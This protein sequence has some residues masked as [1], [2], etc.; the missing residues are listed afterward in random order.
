MTFWVYMQELLWDTCL[1]EE[2][3]DSRIFASFYCIV[4]IADLLFQ[5]VNTNLQSHQ[6]GINIP[7][8][9]HPLQ[10]LWLSDYL[11]FSNL[12]SKKR[13]FITVLVFSPLIINGTKHLIMLIGHLGFRFSE[14][15]F[16]C[17]VHPPTDFIIHFFFTPVNF[18]FIVLKY[19]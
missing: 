11:L 3:L 15:L 13:C 19:I 9:P 5:V 16:I 7:V 2:L 12:M 14:C 18:F 17:F 6:Q 1:G 4:D 10:Y 8:A